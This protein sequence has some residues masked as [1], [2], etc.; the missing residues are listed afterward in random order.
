MAWEWQASPPA[1][2]KAVAITNLF[3]EYLKFF[4]FLSLCARLMIGARYVRNGDGSS[5]GRAPELPLDPYAKIVTEH[6]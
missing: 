5:V 2:A 1:A 3:Q 6:Y 4:M